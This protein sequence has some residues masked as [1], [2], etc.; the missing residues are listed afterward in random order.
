MLLAANGVDDADATGV[1]EALLLGVAGADEVS[2]KE[3]DVT[4]TALDTAV[5]DELTAAELGTGDKSFAG[6][7]EPPPPQAVR[8]AAT[9][10]KTKVDEK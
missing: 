5:N 8:V 3:L 1:D 10:I 7:P 9:T 2:F 6:L 4:T